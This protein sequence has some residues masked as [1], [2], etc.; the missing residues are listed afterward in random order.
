M[1]ALELKHLAGNT[2]YIP[3]PTNIGL[4]VDGTKVVCID[5]GNDKE[6]GRQIN[7]LVTEQGWRLKAVVNTHSNADHI[8]GNAFLQNKTGCAVAATAP[9]APFIEHPEL[10]ASFL[11][12]GYPL[13]AMKNKFLTA[14]P[15][16]VT[17]IIPESGAVP[18]T[19]L[20][21]L[22]LPGHF[23]GMIG[24]RTPDNILFTADALFPPGI[25]KK[26]HVFY[27]YDISAHLNTLNM[28]EEESA[29]LFIP[30]HGEPVSSLASLITV[31]RKKIEEILSVLI[32][33]CSRPKRFDDILSE[34]AS[35][36]CLTIDHN[37]YIL[38]GSALRSYLAYLEKTGRI[39]HHT[40]NHTLVWEKGG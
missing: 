19:G 16:K 28:L 38:I 12:G 36:F 5:S 11:Y 35:R 32:E 17:D 21:S 10:E 6:A 37:Q 26:Y 40:E 1:A 13:P 20:S 4:Y 7:K 8:G 24:L 14:K 9:E 39:A 27:L 34:T 3:A 22:P 2:W 18:G 29:D 25:I 23:F 15:S 30:S 33:V 31:N